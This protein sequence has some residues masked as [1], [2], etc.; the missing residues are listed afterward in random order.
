MPNIPLPPSGV[1]GPLGDYLHLLWRTLT[2]MPNISAF[3][4]P[5]PNSAVTGLPGDLAVNMGSASTASRLWVMAGGAREPSLTGWSAVRI[6][7]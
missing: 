5:S 6:L 3:S 4:G 7:Q 1:T 2:A